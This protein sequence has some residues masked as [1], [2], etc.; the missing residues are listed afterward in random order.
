MYVGVHGEARRAQVGLGVE[1]GG[2]GEEELHQE[3]AD[4]A[5]PS[6]RRPQASL[7]LD[8]EAAHPLRT[9]NDGTAIHVFTHQIVP[10]FHAH[11]QCL[12]NPLI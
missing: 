3:L 9:A 2:D 4:Q 1:G 8:Q 11:T 5:I 12:G 10:S 6:A 7:G